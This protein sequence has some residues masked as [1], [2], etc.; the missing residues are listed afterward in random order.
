[1]NGPRS[2]PRPLGLHLA[3]AT[4]IALSVGPGYA[5]ARAGAVPWPDGLRDEAE[6][7]LAD[8]AA[9]DPAR[10][11]LAIAE[12][13]H[14]RL[15]RM[16]S[17]IDKYQ[18]HS[19]RRDLADPP[20]LWREGSTRLLD[21][22]PGDAAPGDRLPILFVPSLINRAYVLDLMPER[23]LMRHLAARGFRPL[24]L[25]W[26]MPGADE[27]AFDLTAY[28]AGRLVRALDVAVDAHDGR[29]VGLAGYCMG[30][31]L[32]V[33]VATLA[34]E[35]IARLALLATPWDFHAELN[36]TAR[37]LATTETLWEP[38]L[39]A[40]GELP[41]DYLQALFA[42]LDPG[43]AMRKFSRF[44]RLDPAGPHAAEFVALEDW[45]NDGVALPAAV[46]RECLGGWYGANSTAGGAWR[47]AGQIV[48]PAA[49]RLPTMA[50][51]PARDRIVPRPSALAL[52]GTIPDCRILT[53]PSGHIG[54]VTSARAPSGLWRDLED[55][56][57]G[58]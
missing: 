31:N 26:G 16:I 6:G 48:D 23:S 32:A 34:P 51:I 17:G 25:D 43:L 38:V 15:G 50:A 11:G 47:I 29:P 27:R 35:R 3:V 44:D 12:E 8:M 9:H 42:S 14:A 4:G 7:L 46:A 20:V 37:M 55:W 40:V 30:G 58:A 22:G 13:G 21:F 1:M 56:F 33:A 19:Y 36:P 41:V 24:L 2:G 18:G 39:A 57:A 28:V 10:L 5:A 45:L 53:P 49:V 52:A 54:M